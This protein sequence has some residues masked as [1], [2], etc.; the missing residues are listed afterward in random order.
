MPIVNCVASV[1]YCHWDVQLP[2]GV[3]D[4]YLTYTYRPG[5]CLYVYLHTPL[6]VRVRMLFNCNDSPLVRRPAGSPSLQ[7]GLSITWRRVT[8]SGLLRAGRLTPVTV[9]SSPKFRRQSAFSATV[10]S[11]HARARRTQHASWVHV[12]SH[13][14]M[15]VAVTK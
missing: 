6:A 14:S 8:C 10:I 9:P 1:T 4:V 15:P 2:T 7:P 5:V 12:P 3:F 11:F 13:C